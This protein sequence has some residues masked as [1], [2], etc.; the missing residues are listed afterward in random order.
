M[1]KVLLT[2]VFASSIIL[3]YTQKSPKAGNIRPYMA[4]RQSANVE[5]YLLG[6]EIG[7]MNGSRTLAVY[8]SF[9][10]RP[11][12]KKIQQHEAPGIIYQ[13][14]ER[15]MFIGAGME[16]FHYLPHQSRGLCLSLNGNYVW[17]TY[18]GTALKPDAGFILTPRIGFF[19][20]LAQRTTFFKFGYE[21][22]DTQSRV[23]EH[24]F[25]FSVVGVIGRMK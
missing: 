10:F 15:R 22:L 4:F 2:C 1:K 23:L 14:A 13:Y 20:S 8:S 12:R 7:A 19:Q 9:D 5:D 11:Y 18:G 3:G 25:F 21:Y 6:W 16:Y 17:G 24:R